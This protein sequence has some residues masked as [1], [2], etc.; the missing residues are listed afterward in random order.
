MK[1]LVCGGRDFLDYNQINR[2]LNR[3]CGH[4]T[5]TI[6]QGGANGADFLAKVYAYYYGLECH[7]YN[8]E[9]G[10][11]GVR[12]GPIRNQRML[13][14]GEPDLVVA[15]PGGRGTSDMIKRSEKTGV[16]TVVLEPNVDP[17]NQF[18]LWIAPKST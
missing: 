7:Q 2:E 16:R 1:V 13:D 9:W 15:V 6:I 17:Y 12:A 10:D 3:L 5:P 18:N 8:A 4:T 11:L 14:E